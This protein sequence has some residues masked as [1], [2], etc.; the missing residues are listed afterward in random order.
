MNAYSQD[1]KSYNLCFAAKREFRHLITGSQKGLFKNQKLFLQEPL[2]LGPILMLF[3][4]KKWYFLHIIPLRP[5]CYAI[6]RKREGKKENIDYSHIIIL[7]TFHI[8]L[9]NEKNT[10][11]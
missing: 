5:F 4:S 11:I 8:M 7:F 6:R 3:K 10:I 1:Y 9:K 2:T